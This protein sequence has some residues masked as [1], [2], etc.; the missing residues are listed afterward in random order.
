LHVTDWI[1]L[2][3][4]IYQWQKIFKMLMKFQ[5]LIENLQVVL[6]ACLAERQYSL[7]VIVGIWCVERERVSIT[8][9]KA[10]SL[11]DSERCVSIRSRQWMEVCH[12]IFPM[13]RTLYLVRNN[14]DVCQEYLICLTLSLR[15]LLHF[16]L[17]MCLWITVIAFR[18]ESK[19]SG[20]LPFLHICGITSII[21]FPWLDC[22]KHAEFFK[23]WVIL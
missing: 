16:S 19:F 4:D 13:I 20:G 12:L 2:S 18:P 7:N 5:L 14:G 6:C 22:L 21:Y 1:Y 9:L 10:A 15:E 3:E 17:F 11:L 23:F 8:S